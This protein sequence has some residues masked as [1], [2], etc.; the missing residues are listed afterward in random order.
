[1]GSDAAAY[2]TFR[3]GVL[4]IRRLYVE[5]ESTDSASRPLIN[6][7]LARHGSGDKSDPKVGARCA[8]KGCGSKPIYNSHAI[9]KSIGL[10]P[11]VEE[12][13]VVRPDLSDPNDPKVARIG[14]HRASTFNGYCNAHEQL[15]SAAF[16]R[17]R[18][19]T[20]PYH[21]A[22]QL[23][24]SAAREAWKKTGFINY[25]DMNVDAYAAGID[26]LSISAEE[27]QAW[28][29]RIVDPL[30]VI[31]RNAADELELLTTLQKQLVAVHKGSPLP[32]QI[33]VFEYNSNQRVAI[34]GSTYFKDS[35]ALLENQVVQLPPH[36]IVLTAFPNKTEN[37]NT[38][39]LVGSPAGYEV[40]LDAYVAAHLRSDQKR[41]QTVRE[42]M[43]TGT[44]HW[45]AS[46]SWWES[47]PEA[48]RGLIVEGLKAF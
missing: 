3:Q 20:T 30:R 26:W 31:R 5:W 37:G 23:M 32:S 6:R 39:M 18:K 47:L 40:L 25:M 21:H 13:H 10:D 2:R 14:R 1:M 28:T 38:L 4:D 7:A 46:P 43:T 48:E 36:T 15:F 33:R 27:K 42:W 24:R 16:E 44:D 12:G 41:E 22:L 11:L 9:T 17:H 8:Y 35:T 29:H 34:S 19:L 45:F